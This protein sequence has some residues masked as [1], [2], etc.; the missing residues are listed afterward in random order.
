[1]S[2]ASDA[3]TGA[4]DG[5]E[6][7][8]WVGWVAQDADGSWWGYEHEPNRSDDGWY[9]NEVGRCLRIAAGCVGPGWSASLQRVRRG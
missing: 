7:P 5:R 6:L 2:D 3:P 8:H 4:D 1:M 9:E